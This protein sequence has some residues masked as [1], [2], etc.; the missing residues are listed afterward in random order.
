MT[1]VEQ[2]EQLTAQ[3]TDLTAK[4]SELTA[5][6]AAH[7]DHAPIAAKV[8]ELEGVVAANVETVAALT[9][10][11]DEAKADAQK[12]RDAMALKPDAFQHI[13][14]GA[15]PVQDGAASAD[16]PLLEKLAELQRTDARAARDF[17]NKHKA[18]IKQLTK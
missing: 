7:V 9:K 14:D 1:P 8:T 18:A 5:Q 15:K 4:V 16:K 17:Y 2:I 12:L 11:R 6:I 3:N 13:T 10:E